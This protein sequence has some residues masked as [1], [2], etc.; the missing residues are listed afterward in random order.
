MPALPE[1]LL[2]PLHDNIVM[3]G[4]DDPRASTCF[5][6]KNILISGPHIHFT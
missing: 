4:F 1:T 3:E 5:K 2:M 6:S